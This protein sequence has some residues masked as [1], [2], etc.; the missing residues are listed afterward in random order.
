MPFGGWEPAAARERFAMG[1][2][3][4]KTLR[5]R[6]PGLQMP[7]LL[8]SGWSHG[9]SGGGNPRTKLLLSVSL[10]LVSVSPSNACGISRTTFSTG[11][12]VQVPSV[13]W[14]STKVVAFSHPA[15]TI[16]KQALCLGFLPRRG[17]P[18]GRPRPLA[19]SPFGSTPLFRVRRTAQP[20]PRIINPATLSNWCNAGTPRGIP[21]R[22][23]IFYNLNPALMPFKLTT[24]SSRVPQAPRACRSDL[25]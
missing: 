25:I 11:F 19:R 12:L 14:Y 7:I 15:S 5:S 20:S 10:V 21:N 13:L 1:F 2:D 8:Y 9:A 17:H 24:P 3:H 16:L 23:T 18:S 22:T 4:L 6:P